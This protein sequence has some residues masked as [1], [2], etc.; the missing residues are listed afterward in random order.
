MSLQPINSPYMMQMGQQKGFYQP[1]MQPQYKPLP[2][3]QGYPYGDK[4]PPQNP[5]PPG[6]QPTDR[7]D[8]K[9]KTVKIVCMIAV[10]IGLFWFLY[11]VSEGYF[12]SS[13]S[14]NVEQPINNNNDVKVYNNETTNQDF[15]VDL[16]ASVPVT[17]Q[18]LTVNCYSGGCNGNQTS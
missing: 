17:I 8:K 14:N 18:Q 7:S 10:V 16:N 13:N 4:R 12:K 15:Q 11:L 9:Y 6:Y 5:A 1:Q 3:G 2:T